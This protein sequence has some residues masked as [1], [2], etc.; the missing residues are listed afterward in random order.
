MIPCSRWEDGLV[1][2][3]PF[4][5]PHPSYPT[6]SDMEKSFPFQG[7][8]CEFSTFLLA[9]SGKEVPHIFLIFGGKDLCCMLC[10]TETHKVF[11]MR[12]LRW[13]PGNKLDKSSTFTFNQTFFSG[14]SHQNTSKRLYSFI[15]VRF[16]VVDGSVAIRRGL[17][18]LHSL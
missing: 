15:S 10:G 16:V 12:Y 2:P 18:N 13:R 17:F 11:I 5:G 14:L 7:G 4:L 3:A 9:V 8:I 6:F 1:L